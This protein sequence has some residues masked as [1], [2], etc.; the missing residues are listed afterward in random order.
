MFPASSYKG[1]AVLGFPD[2][3]KVPA[4]PA[5]QVPAPMPNIGSSQ[6]G[7][8][9]KTVVGSKQPVAA[10]NASQQDLVKTLDELHGTIKSMTTH[11]ASVWHEAVD[12]Y[13]MAVAA[14]YMSGKNVSPR[15]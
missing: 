1:G 4:P 11:D 8:A 15:G 14:V 2:V 5:P 3:C 12:K 7:Q 6:A 13:V 9:S 10:K